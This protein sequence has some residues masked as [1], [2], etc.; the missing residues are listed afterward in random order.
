M[1]RERRPLPPSSSA[2]A[3]IWTSAGV[4]T[5]G[6]ST[7]IELLPSASS[8]GHHMNPLAQ[9]PLRFN[10]P[11]PVSAWYFARRR[12]RCARTA[13]PAVV[14]VVPDRQRRPDGKCEVVDGLLL[15]LAR[16]QSVR[17]GAIG[18]EAGVEGEAVG[19]HGGDDP[20]R[21]PFGQWQRPRSQQDP[22]A[23]LLVAVGLTDDEHGPGSVAVAHG[24]DR[25][26]LR[27]GADLARLVRLA[28]SG[29]VSVAMPR[30]WSK[31]IVGHA[32]H[33]QPGVE[34]DDGRRPLQRCARG[35]R[36]TRW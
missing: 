19:V 35:H 8:I 9:S 5:S 29:V 4:S 30:Y 34:L 31:C 14:L 10:V 15:G 11:S 32:G 6:S 25:P 27:R 23:A 13:H 22:E 28:A 18:Q 21:D 1:V 36:S 20:Q 16:R 12:R 33:R 26:P 2:R 7:R 24:H 17:V 3:W